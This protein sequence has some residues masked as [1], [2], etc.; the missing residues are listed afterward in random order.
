MDKD[1]GKH[2]NEPHDKDY[3]YVII[4]DLSDKSTYL[5]QEMAENVEK[6]LARKGWNVTLRSP[7]N[8]EPEGTYYT[9]KDGSLQIL[10]YS[11]PHIAELNL[12]F[13]NAVNY[14]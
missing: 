4:T 7:R 11:I 3:A 8:G 10:G 12:D 6:I 13:F 5:T 2:P 1:T 9:T 14:V